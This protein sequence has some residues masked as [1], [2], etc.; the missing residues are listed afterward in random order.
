MKP[1][2]KKLLILNA[3]Y[4]LFV[5]LFMKIGE[6]FR[7][8]PGAD[9]SGKLLHIMEGVTAAF[10][11]PMPSLNGAGFSY[12]R[13]RG[14]Y[15]ADCRLHER[16][17]RQE[18]PQGNAVFI[19]SKVLHEFYSEDN[20][21][22]PNFVCYP[23]FIAPI[24]TRIYNQYVQPIISSTIN[25][26]IFSPVLPWQKEILDIL[27]EIFTQQNSAC[28]K[29]LITSSLLQKLWAVFFEHID[30]THLNQQQDHS[31]Q[32]QIKLQVMMQYIHTNY[33][34]QIALSDIAQSAGISKSSALSF[35]HKYLKMAPVSYLILYR[36]KKASELLIT[37]DLKLVEIAY[38]TGFNNIGYFCKQY[39]IH[40]GITPTEYRKL[41]AQRK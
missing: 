15:P 24:E 12:R 37:T 11:S 30:T 19:N 38:A 40:Y 2:I 7:L 28:A 22:I 39:K 23:T 5:W 27:Q 1:K 20:A 17:E 25:Y 33:S 29:E 14:G 10:E 26:Q 21:V 32:S 8:S 4:L 34:S 16:Q 35:F 18:V 6:A 3:P 41:K 36:L 13:C 31:A 9:L